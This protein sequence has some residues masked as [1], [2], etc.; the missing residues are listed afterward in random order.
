MTDLTGLCVELR[1]LAEKILSLHMSRNLQP[2]PLV[3]EGL[4]TAINGLEFAAN[5]HGRR[6]HVAMDSADYKVVDD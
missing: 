1:E 4:Q 3:L 5:A 6:P 2:N